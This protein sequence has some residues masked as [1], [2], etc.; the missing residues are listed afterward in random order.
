[1]N[2]T[3]NRVRSLYDRQIP[4]IFRGGA[5][6]MALVLIVLLVLSVFIKY[7]ETIETPIDIIGS[8]NTKEIIARQTGRLFLYSSD[9]QISSEDEVLASI[10]S[11]SRDFYLIQPQIEAIDSNLNL[12]FNPSYVL[13][14]SLNLGDIQASY[15][16]L[17]KKREEF[18]LS[19][20]QNLYTIQRNNLKLS[21][22]SQEKMLRQA[23]ERLT[24]SKKKL[25]AASI[26]LNNGKTLL[27]K[28][29]ISEKDYYSYA[30]NYYS[31]EMA[32]MEIEAE[33]VELLN[34]IDNLQ[35]N[36]FSN[37][38]E[39]KRDSVTM[40]SN[41]MQA[42]RL[43]CSEIRKWEYEY[44]LTA[45][46]NG[47]LF[48]SSNWS[49]G[50]IIH[51]GEVFAAIIPSDIGAIFCEAF[52]GTEKYGDLKVNQDVIIHLDGYEYERY[53]HIKGVLKDISRVPVIDANGRYYYK[54]SISLSSNR[55]LTSQN[56][57]IPF[58][59]NLHGS[60]KIVLER[61]SLLAKL[62]YKI[63]RRVL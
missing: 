49:D 54:L 26:E 21:L 15:L 30:N 38:I 39:S 10:N 45:P 23:N 14:D 19:S 24:F 25:E 60:A 18:F 4:F 51:S 44:V 7:P 43:F 12:L 46:C 63:K 1:M 59:P 27:D 56:Y 8:N 5:A 28:K 6:I 31:C 32:V 37:R 52:V 62:F 57:E 35:H 50:D 22:A 34:S 47:R 9:F 20:N 55:L 58:S 61:T 16:N 40:A 3:S 29:A 11:T 42:Y 13:V 2:E 17:L 36:L 48:F 33:I 53:G 41:L